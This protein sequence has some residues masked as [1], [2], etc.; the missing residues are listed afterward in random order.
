MEGNVYFDA[1]AAERETAF[2]GKG[3]ELMVFGEEL[4]TS[5]LSVSLL[6][7]NLSVGEIAPLE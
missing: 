1:C 7:P 4:P 5:R 3:S 2:E 6:L